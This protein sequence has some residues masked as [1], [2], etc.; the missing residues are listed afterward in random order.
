MEEVVGT[1]GKA[2]KWELPV[3][4]RATDE[5][6]QLEKSIE[7]K[8]GSKWTDRA[9]LRWSIAYFEKRSLDLALFS[10]SQ[11]GY[12]RCRFTEAC[13]NILNF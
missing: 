10:S 4:A 2:S 7:G 6:D 9:K 11:A 1:L 12:T 5:V 3:N 13:V 8:F